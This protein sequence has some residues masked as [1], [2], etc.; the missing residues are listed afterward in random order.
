MRYRVI[1]P[2]PNGYAWWGVIDTQKENTEI[3]RIY[4]EID[5]AEKVCKRISEILN[6]RCK[7][8]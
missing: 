3:V 6:A 2:V 1:P 8:A 5:F 4:Y 7:E